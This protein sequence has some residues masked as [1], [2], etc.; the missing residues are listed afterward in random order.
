MNVDQQSG[1]SSAWQVAEASAKY[2]L[3]QAEFELLT[4]VTVRRVVESGAQLIHK[5]EF[6]R[7]MYLIERGEVWLEFGNE[8]PDKILG[9]GEYFGELVLF[10]GSHQRMASATAMSAA[11][12]HVLDKD[13][14][15]R[16]LHQQPLPIAEF[17]GR[18]FSRLVASEQQLIARLRRRNEDLLQVINQLRR[19][20]DRLQLAE[21]QVHSDDL[22]GLCN[23]RGLYAHLENLHQ[24]TSPDC[25]LA[26]LL[27]DIDAFKRVNDLHGHLMGDRVLRAVAQ[28]LESTAGAR[29]LPIRLGGDE[30]AL[31]AEVHDR[32]DLLS[33]AE[34]LQHTLRQYVITH[35]GQSISCS[36]SMGGVLC[37]AQ[38]DWS[39]WY[40]DADA[41]LYRAKAQGGDTCDLG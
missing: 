4:S 31:L 11:I 41:A 26:L 35:Q 18:S 39:Q 40:S 1:T 23:R 21:S 22:T 33:L 29:D 12:V 37:S 6:G 15:K 13:M 3:S 16:L 32:S 10:I 2:A 24:N 17:M 9:P 20:E 25:Q 34:R 8:Q 27:V 19:T 36:V 14:F 38:S 28:V 30:F 5:G 7:S